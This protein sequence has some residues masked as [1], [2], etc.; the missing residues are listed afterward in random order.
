MRNGSLDWLPNETT[1]K[2][3]EDCDTGRTERWWFYEIR[4]TARDYFA[5][6]IWLW[7]K[8]RS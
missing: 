3:L 4:Q 1:R 2:A 8:L 7:R 5:P 6:M